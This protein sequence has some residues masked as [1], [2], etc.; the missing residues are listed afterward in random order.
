MLDQLRAYFTSDF[1]LL[2][3]ET[4]PH[5][6]SQLAGK[7]LLQQEI[8]FSE[9]EIS[10]LVSSSVL[11]KIESIEHYLWGHRCRRCGNKHAHLFA[12]IPHKKCGKECV[13]CRSCIQMGRVMECEPLYI[14]NAAIEWPVYEHPCT[15]DG[16][17]TNHQQHAADEI[18]RLVECGAGEKLIWAVCGAGKTEMLFP[19]LTTAL[20]KGKRVCLATPRTD[21]VRELLPRLQRAFPEVKI[22]ALYGESPDKVG[23]ASFILATT[24]Q[25]LRFAHAFD[26]MIIDEVDAFPFHNDASLHFASKRAAK[27]EASILYLTAT[28][29]KVQKKRI[30]AKQLPAVFIP[31]RYHGHPLPVPHLKL[32]PTLHRYMKKGE[33]P[34]KVMKKIADQQTTARQLLLFL[35]SIAKAEEVAVLLDDKGYLVQSVHAEDENRAEKIHAFREQKYRILVTTTILERGVTFPSVDVYVIDAGHSV[36]DE[37]ALVQIAGR[38]GRS[39]QDPTGE[40]LFYHIGK[41]D[42]MLDAVNA[43][44]YMNRLASRS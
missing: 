26:V 24:H 25:L 5:N 32:T 18:S 6:Y 10:Q 41:T 27:P 19:G 16:T 3:T 33:L 28:P 20:Q 21:V 23:N 38:A 31:E 34:E 4:P 29:R 43:I 37:A 13:Y 8:P 14:G 2:S 1:P 11:S 40:V 15:W 39:Q 44:T 17:L 30:H 7:L 12:K 9:E 35:P 22:Q 42:A 36:F